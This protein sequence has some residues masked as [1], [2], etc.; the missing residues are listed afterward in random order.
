MPQPNTVA[1]TGTLR[2]VDGK[3]YEGAVIRVWLNSQMNYSNSL[4]GNEIRTVYSNSYGR[5]R[6]NLVPSVVDAERE[7]YYVFNIIKDTVNTYKKIINGSAL[8]VDFEDLP[9]FIP[10]GL[11]TPLIGNINRNVNPNPIT[12]PQELIGIF[13]WSQFQADGATNVFT[14]PG[15]VSF[16]ALNG[17]VQSEG[18]DYI[19][20]APNI[21]EFI[22]TPLVDDIVALQ[23]RI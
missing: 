1:V 6:I 14:A 16:V 3:L 7:N 22:S 18:I 17:V 15:E 8:K 4:M 10:Q 23:Y 2:D 9:D 12:L 21:I 5:F 13:Q 11:R 20:Q 19:K